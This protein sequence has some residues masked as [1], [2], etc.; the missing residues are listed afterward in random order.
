MPN[1]NAQD[2]ILPRL[3]EYGDITIEATLDELKI[4]QQ[5]ISALREATLDGDEGLDADAKDRL[6]NPIREL[7]NLDGDPHLRAGIDIYLN[8]TN[9]SEET[10][11]DVRQSVHAYLDRLGVDQAENSM[12]SLFTVK[13]EVGMLTGVHSI[14]TDMC[15]N[16]CIAYTGP[17]AELDTCFYCSEPR[18]DPAILAASNGEQKRS[19]R[20]FHTLP[21]GPQLQ[22]I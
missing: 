17:F 6:R 14:M 12:P 3:T 11:K 21:V 13:K 18:Y 16:T 2:D 8:T 19:R 5:F 7:V 22:A 9:A 1:N 10:Y 20:Q 15:I 4:S